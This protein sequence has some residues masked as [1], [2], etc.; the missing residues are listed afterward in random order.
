MAST[1]DPAQKAKPVSGH[2][3]HSLRRRRLS[4]RTGGATCRRSPCRSGRL[5]GRRPRPTPARTGCGE[6]F[7]GGVPHAESAAG[8]TRCHIRTEG[9][10][11]CRAG[12]MGAVRVPW[13][14]A[15]CRGAPCGSQAVPR[16]SIPLPL[17]LPIPNPDPD[18]SPN[19]D[20]EP[21]LVRVHIAE[22][23]HA[24]PRVNVPDLNAVVAR[25]GDH[26][27]G[28]GVRVRVRGGVRGG[29]QV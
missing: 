26:L 17:P 24:L 6:G 11:G 19:P 20:P 1:R 18:P 9:C 27:V 13:G 14:A 5:A 29:V 22:G 15:G 8:S 4:A 28:V 10:S 21:H 12:A 3:G 7:G 2:S 23:L 25:A 16:T